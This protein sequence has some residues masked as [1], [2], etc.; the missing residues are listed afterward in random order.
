MFLV[1]G[2]TFINLITFLFFLRTNKEVA[3]NVLAKN[4]IKFT[5]FKE[6]ILI[7]FFVMV[8][9]LMSKL[10]LGLDRMFVDYF[11]TLRDFAIYSFV[12]SI[13]NLFNVLFSAITTVVYPYLSRAKEEKRGQIY[14]RTKLV[15]FF[16]MGLAISI[17][18]IFVPIINSFLP[19]YKESIPI[20]LVLIPTVLI[21]CQIIIVSFNFYKVMGYQKEFTINNIFALATGFITNVIFYYVMKSMMGIALASL[22]SFVIWMIFTD[23][24]FT[25]KLN[26]NLLKLNLCQLTLIASF[27]A[28]GVIVNWYIGLLVYII[29]YLIII[30]VF[31]KKDLIE[32]FKNKLNYLM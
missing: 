32:L 17:Y 29:V 9:N 4:T 20:L 31:Y 10:I 7:G 8:G 3:G 24:F 5:E 2:Q 19:Q 26:I 30:W 11:F 12:I 1:V 23:T 18:Y 25:K 13:L 6:L 21:S 14:F 22:L 15:L 27:I 28:L 16:L